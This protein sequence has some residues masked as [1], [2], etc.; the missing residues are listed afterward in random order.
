MAFKQQPLDPSSY[1]MKLITDLGQ[2]P[3][4]PNPSRSIRH[5]IFECPI[6]LTH[7][8]ARA[9]GAK[10]HTQESCINCIGS[11]NLSKDPL[12]AIWN[13]IKQRCYNPKRKDYHRYGGIGVTMHPEWIESPVLFI[14]WCRSNGWRPDLVIDKDIKSEQLG[15]NPPIYSPD[16]LSFISTIEN[17]KAANAKKVSQY[18]LINELI[19]E[20]KSCTDAATS[21]GKPK[22]AKS[23]IANCCR[24][25]SKTAFGFIWKFSE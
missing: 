15:I 13:G 21:L 18:S 20:H 19:A 4:K 9:V 16:T 2:V 8:E 17:A 7:F 3:S 5:A 11:H 14:E 6:C 10:A 12:Y 25:I 22:T 24:G 1:K 23:S